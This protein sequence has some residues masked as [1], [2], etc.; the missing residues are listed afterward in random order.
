MP[1]S[2]RGSLSLPPGI[3]LK[4]GD[5]I[6]D[7]DQTFRDP[8][9]SGLISN[10]R[11][12]S[13]GSGIGMSI[14]PYGFGERASGGVWMRGGSGRFDIEEEDEGDGKGVE[15]G[16][17]EEEVKKA[18]ETLYKQGLEMRKKVVGEEYV[19]RS[20]KAAS[21]DFG[22]VW[23]DYATVSLDSFSIIFCLFLFIPYHISST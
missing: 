18:H 2:A 9:F 7:Y 4:T 3:I 5:H 14:D 21:E 15:K 23:Q 6:P 17:L 13:V 8:D 12:S 22:K 16:G 19:E 11:N 10:T 20:L 1:R